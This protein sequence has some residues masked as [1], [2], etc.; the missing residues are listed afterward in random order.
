MSKL[1]VPVVEFSLEE[2][3]N[4]DSLSIARVKGWQVVVRTQDFKDEKLAVYVP[5][6]AIADKN[7]PLLSF[8]EGKKVKTIKLR[9]AV[10]QGVLLPYSVVSRYLQYEPKLGDNLAKK[11]NIK[12]YEAPLKTGPLVQKVKGNKN[13]TYISPPDW[14]SKFTDIENWKNYPDKIKDG[15][16]VVITEKLHGTNARFGISRKGKIFI[17]SHNKTLRMK[18]KKTLMSKFKFWERKLPD[19]PKSVWSEVY[20]RLNLEEK[21]NILH[22]IYPESNIVLYGEIVGPKIQD[23]TYNCKESDLFV[24]GLMVNGRYV[25]S[26]KTKNIV[27]RCLDLNFVPVLHTGAFRASLLD[28]ANGK[29]V[30]N[31]AT[32]VREGIVIE[33]ITRTFDKELGR[34][35]LK[36]VSEE[37]YLRKDAKDN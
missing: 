21:L 24:F 3:P 11:L 34:L 36:C 19:P 18:Q 29:T 13:L 33:C 16:L 14:F 22:K 31:G 8:L 26:T 1:N 28:T 10:S 25:S 27:K 7:H 30:V 2:H 17:G 32:H 6:D 4:A 35:I 20:E 37:Y 23:L 9:K 15:D 5:L 12:K